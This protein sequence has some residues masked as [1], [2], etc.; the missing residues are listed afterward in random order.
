MDQLSVFD[1]LLCLAPSVLIGMVER[2]W[3][4]KLV[5]EVGG[6]K[7]K[8]EATWMLSE[9]EKVRRCDITGEQRNRSEFSFHTVPLW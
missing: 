6:F 9:K 4:M 8:L 1:D 3:G 2:E 5:E 7:V